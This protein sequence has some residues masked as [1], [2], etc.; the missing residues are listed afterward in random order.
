MV[1]EQKQLQKDETKINPPTRLTEFKNMNTQMLQ[2]VSGGMLGLGLGRDI[3]KNYERDEVMDIINGNDVGRQVALSRHF[4][5]K[6]G[7][8]KRL[9]SHYATL[10][11]FA[12]ILVPNEDKTVTDSA[13]EKRYNKALKYVDSTNVI[14]M[15]QRITL[16]VLTEGAY[17]GLLPPKGHSR[18]LSDLPFQ[19]CRTRFRDE[20]GVELVELNLAYFTTLADDE[21]RD[22]ILNLY[23]KHI[24]ETYISLTKGNANFREFW[25]VLDPS[26]AVVFR[27]ANSCRPQLLHIIPTSMD[28]DDAVTRQA[29][30]EIEEIKKVIVQKIPHLADGTLLFEPVEAAE[31][32]KGMVNMMAHNN[33]NTSIMTTYGDVE[34]LTTKVNADPASTNNL[35]KMKGNIYDTA[36]ASS[37]VFSATGNIAMENSLKNDLAYLI[38]LVVDY[39]NWLTRVVND[40]AGNTK[41]S[42]HYQ[43]LPVT[44]YNETE[45]I[46]NAVA[47]A[48]YG[49]S[50]LI[51]A[52]A[53][54]ITQKDLVSLK[55]LENN[56]LKLDKELLPLQSSHTMS[57]DDRREA[58]GRPE[59][60]SDE[61]SDKTI[62]N[63]SAEEKT[64]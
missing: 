34:S 9:V 10:F 30:R 58:V 23:P 27:L 57:A 6:D 40:Y 20:N 62:A 54:G 2:S 35:Q 43:F 36:G 25:V 14:S 29:E 49:Y 46:N 55:R 59:L 4:Y 19:Y 44:W 15:F 45:Y 32:H 39:S 8:Y 64:S 17:Y 52:V 50:I 41:I 11:K 61:K 37:Q 47:M 28:Y 1:K 60:D 18:H 5:N 22:L 13:L 33:P 56:L 16:K 24:R 26:E 51:P 38:P 21:Y 12:G 63:E 3:T 7:F 53:M 48:S 31:M 42:F